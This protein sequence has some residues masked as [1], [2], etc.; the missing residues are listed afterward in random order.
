MKFW[1]LFIGLLALLPRPGRAQRYQ[2]FGLNAGVNA[3]S[4]DRQAV[5][6]LWDA[7]LGSGF[8]EPSRFWAPAEVARY[9]RGDVLLSEGYVHP[10][11]YQYATQKV[12]LSLQAVDSA[13]Y[14]CRT[15][16]Y[17]PNPADTLQPLT[18][19]CIVNTYMHRQHGQWRLVNHLTRATR[20]W[21]TD[22]V[23]YFASLVGRR[24]AFLGRHN[25]RNIRA[26]SVR[27]F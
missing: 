2:H 1:C 24:P 14:K 6:G 26:S 23:G 9:R 8:T 12:V 21:A 4:P 13:Q 5:L 17:W 22:T 11:V 3:A 25:R 27:Q 16:F 10:S 7:Y 19:F 15:L 20:D 18:V